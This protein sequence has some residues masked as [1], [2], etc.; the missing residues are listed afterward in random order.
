M[1]NAPRALLKE[2]Q[3]CVSC[4]EQVPASHRRRPICDVCIGPG[5]ARSYC[6]KCGRRDRY[7]FEDFVRVMS[8]H[9]PQFDFSEGTCVRLPACASCKD[10]G[11]PPVDGGLIRY[12]GISFD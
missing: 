6:A 4:A 1:E 2:P 12:Y 11:K 3:S 10:D 7:P 9:Y 8:R 5:E